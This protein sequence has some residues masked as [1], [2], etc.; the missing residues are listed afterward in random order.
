MFALNLALGTFA[1]ASALF[2]LTRLLESWRVGS[3]HAPD[4]VSVLGQ[5][6]SYP[7]ANAGAIVVA[8]LGGM[9]LLVL[10]A[11]ARAA[12]RELRRA[13]LRRA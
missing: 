4:V 2:V 13:C 9:G 5:R 7:V 8:A 12:V 11:A 3:G 10:V 6:L 1:L